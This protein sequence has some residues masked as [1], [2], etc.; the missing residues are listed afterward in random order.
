MQRTIRFAGALLILICFSGC[1][2]FTTAN[3]R[4]HKTYAHSLTEWYV[5]THNDLS[6]L[7]EKADEEGKEFLETEV[8]PIFNDAGEKI[9]LYI[10]LLRLWEAGG[11]K[12]LDIDN[13]YSQIQTAILRI[14]E[15]IIN[16]KR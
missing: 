7:H 4:R 10:D 2:V 3:F 5:T 1:A 12:P 16:F 9:D 11:E 14:T 15:M 8:N 6:A 13:L